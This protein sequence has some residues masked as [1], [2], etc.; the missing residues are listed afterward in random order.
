MSCNQSIARA[1]AH[2]DQPRGASFSRHVGTV[3][4]ISK[5]PGFRE[6]GDVRILARLAGWQPA[7]QHSAPKPQL[8][9]SADIPVR[10]TLRRNF[11][12]GPI[13]GACLVPAA[14]GQECPRSDTSGKIVAGCDDSGR[15]SPD[16][17]GEA[18]APWANVQGCGRMF[19]H[20]AFS[21]RAGACPGSEL[22]RFA[23][24]GVRERRGFRRVGLG[25]TAHFGACFRL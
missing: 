15:S 20:S 24:G 18:C 21:A 17:S 6:I 11:D 16:V 4:P 5:R 14:G 7:A 8:K 2:E 13:E 1:P 19:V 3:S 23:G 12:L 10:R 9:R 25:V 22:V